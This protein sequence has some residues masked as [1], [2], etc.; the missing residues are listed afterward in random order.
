MRKATSFTISSDILSEI[1]SSKGDRSTSDRVNTL[2]RKALELERRERLEEEAAEFFKNAA[3]HVD[4]ETV[5]FLR[6]SK[7]ALSRD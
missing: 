7:K 5:A 1:A 3:D 2:L 4:S 6:A